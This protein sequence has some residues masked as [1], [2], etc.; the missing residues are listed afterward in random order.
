M[1]ESLS[2]ESPGF[3]WSRLVEIESRIMREWL[4]PLQQNL[5]GLRGLK[6]Q[7]ITWL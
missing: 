6:C 2:F 7:E 5:L 3:Q 4:I 1:G